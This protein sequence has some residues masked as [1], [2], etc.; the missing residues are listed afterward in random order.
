[1]N[2]PS[3]KATSHK[4]SLDNLVTYEKIDLDI[5]KKLMNSTLLKNSFRNPFTGEMYSNELEQLEKFKNKI[6]KKGYAKVTYKRKYESYGRSNPLHSLS[7]FSIRREIRQT[8]AFDYYV[9]ID[10]ENCHPVILY[11]ICEKNNIPSPKLKHYINN[12]DIVL[13]ET[14]KAY[15]VDSRDVVKNLYI[16]LMYNSKPQYWKKDNKIAENLNYKFADEYCKELQGIMKIIMDNNEELKNIIYE[17]KKAQGKKEEEM[18]LLGSVSSYYLQNI[19]SQILESI[20]NYCVEKKYIKKNDC[21]LCADG[22]M[23]PKTLYKPQLLEELR[24]LIISKFGLVLNFTQ[25]EM[26][27]HYLN[28]L[29]ESQKKVSLL[30]GEKTY[31]ELKKEFE[32]NHFKVMRPFGYCN[33]EDI[34]GYEIKRQTFKDTYENL[35]YYKIERDPKTNKDVKKKYKFVDEWYQD[36]AIRTYNKCVF[37]PDPHYKNDTEYNL[38]K[39]FKYNNNNTCDEKLIKPLTSLLKHISKNDYPFLINWISWIRQQPHKKTDITVILYSDTHGLGKNALVLL[40]NKI[41]SGFTTKISNMDDL[42]RNFNSEISNKFFLYGD[43]VLARDRDLYNT[44]KNITTQKDLRMEMKGK[45]ARIIDDFINML[46]TTNNEQPVKIEL[47]DRRMALIECPDKK[48]SDAEYKAFFD[49]LEDENVLKAFDNFL[50]NHPLPKKLTPPENEYRERVLLTQ[51]PGFIQM[52]YK[53]TSI[54]AGESYKMSELIE[55]ARTFSK[56]NNLVYNQTSQFVAKHFKQEFGE[57]L[58]KKSDGN[59]Y[60][61]PENL[62]EI[63][64]NKNNK[65]VKLMPEYIDNY[66]EETEIK[67]LPKEASKEPKKDIDIETDSENEDEIISMIALLQKKLKKIQNKKNFVE[68]E[69]KKDVY[70]DDLMSTDFNIDF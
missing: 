54:Y 12:R 35:F 60:C 64:K 2:T 4:S 38:F 5:L 42:K 67:E 41:F 66:E 45:D 32:K 70:D 29:D 43:E 15:N 11:Q 55:E 57:F 59:Y 68:I 8:I 44:I 33:E 52:I 6:D 18:N 49:A 25:K 23:I 1:M 3:L 48:M 40:L 16:R 28:I 24:T 22:L 31:E 65:Y 14:K 21:V 9:D 26:K 47:N 62:S 30:E 58:K 51:T 56:N 34:T 20:Y 27:E 50:K 61:F 36:P 39:G 46:F 53:K 10:I 69:E 63:L 17:S 19:E 7:L 13:E 37:N